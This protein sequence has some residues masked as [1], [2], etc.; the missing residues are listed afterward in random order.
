[1][2]RATPPR[3]QVELQVAEAG[4]RARDRGLRLERQGSS[5]QIGVDDDAG[6]IEHPPQA[7]GQPGAGAGDE[8]DV[9]RG[10]GEDLGPPGLELGAR[11]GHG[12][13]VHGGQRTRTRANRL[14][15]HTERRRSRTFQRGR[16][17]ST[18]F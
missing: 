1:M 2:T 8:I 5:P 16:P 6:R 17:R 15:A 14:V 11:D 10:A 9:I 3:A 13:P 12:Q 4:R 7:R 18:R